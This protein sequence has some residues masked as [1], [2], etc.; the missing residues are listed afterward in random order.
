MSTT[1]HNESTECTRDTVAEYAADKLMGLTLIGPDTEEYNGTRQR[2]RRWFD[3][4][5]LHAAHAL[6][7]ILCDNAVTIDSLAEEPSR[8]IFELFN[9]SH[10]YDSDDMRFKNYIVGMF[11][12]L[13]LLINQPT[14]L[15]NEFIIRNHCS[16]V[17]SLNPTEEGYTTADWNGIYTK[18]RST[19]HGYQMVE[20]DDYSY[21]D[22]DDDDDTS[23]MTDAT[24]ETIVIR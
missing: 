22:D 12:N 2:I 7:S 24:A 5:P 11:G 20:Y 19:W 6:F 13:C 21:G 9:D 16:L 4:I 1:L 14:T 15:S 17:S 23:V 10:L 18:F 3:N 8:D